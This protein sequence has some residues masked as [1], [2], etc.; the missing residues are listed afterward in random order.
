MS[1][2]MRFTCANDQQLSTQISLKVLPKYLIGT[3][4][5]GQYL[6]QIARD[7]IRSTQPLITH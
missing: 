4:P 2:L 7:E 1:S 3:F 6:K 5:D